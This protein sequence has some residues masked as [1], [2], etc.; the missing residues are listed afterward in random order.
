MILTSLDFLATTLYFAISGSV[1]FI[2]FFRC[3]TDTESDKFRFYTY[4]ECHN[5]IML[6]IFINV[7]VLISIWIP[8]MSF[9]Y[10]SKLLTKEH[11][12]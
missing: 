7:M 12:L 6:T 8:L 5:S 10:Y 2:F 3:I 4:V 1:T 11:I 9:Y